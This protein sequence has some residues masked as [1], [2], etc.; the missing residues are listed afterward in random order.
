MLGYEI[1]FGMFL[2]VLLLSAILGGL[3]GA[4]V[5]VG[6]FEVRRLWSGPLERH[7]VRAM[8]ARGSV[9]GACI[10]MVAAIVLVGFNFALH[11]F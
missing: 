4:A 1:V 7:H 10:A 6:Y 11:F 3:L 2:P 5:T 8:A 9:I